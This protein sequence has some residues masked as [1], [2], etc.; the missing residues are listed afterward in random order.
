MPNPALGTWPDTACPGGT[1][2]ARTPVATGVDP[3][4]DHMR[5][6]RTRALLAAALPIAA[7]AVFFVATPSASAA[8]AAFPAH[9][10]APYLQISGGDAGDMAQDMSSRSEEHTSEL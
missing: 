8:G 7:G 1:Y 9:F 5:I 10:A 4:G 2:P 3:T 6:T